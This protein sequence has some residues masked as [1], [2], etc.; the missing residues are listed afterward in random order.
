MKLIRRRLF[1]DGALLVIALTSGILAFVVRRC[2]SPVST[3]DS[4]ALLLPS[5][6]GSPPRSLGVTRDGVTVR[7]VNQSTTSNSPVWY[8][9][10]PWNRTGDLATVDSAVTMLR[11]LQVVRRLAMDNQVTST[12]LASFGLDRPQSAWEVESDG[13][14]YS[15]KIGISAPP[16]RGGTYVELDG[17]S[18]NSRQFFVVSGDI[19]GLTLPPQLLL[20]SRLLP[21]VPSDV[22][23]VRVDSDGNHSAYQFDTARARWFEAD[24]QRRRISREKIEKLLFYLT[25]LKG[26]YLLPALDNDSSKTGKA[27][28]SV[29]LELDKRHAKVLVELSPTCGKWPELSTIRVSG[30]ARVAACAKAEDLT[31]LLVADASSWLDDRLFSVRTDEIEGLTVELDGHSLKLERQELGFSM[32]IPEPR[33]IDI[34]TGNDSLQ[35]L[36][37]IRGVLA[38]SASNIAPADVEGINFIEVRSG[39]VG[40]TDRYAERVLIGPEQSNGQRWLK[41]A[42]DSTFLRLD[43]KA[44]NS[45]KIESKLLAPQP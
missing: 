19:S 27:L 34:D 36:T 22:R 7:I 41:R 6:S 20:E 45:L 17:P 31:T 37:S 28:A 9:E 42:S 23:L 5:L 29:S 15:L 16:P 24:G 40:P 11:D 38:N 32:S 4:P 33:R 3:S 39:V 43:A 13:A 12:N 8:A 26:E 25:N 2:D 1:W 21:Y 30:A 44:A 10:S 35:T 18:P 14:H